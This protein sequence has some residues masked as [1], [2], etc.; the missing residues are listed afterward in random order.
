MNLMC[1]SQR[2]RKNRG[3]W[4]ICKWCSCEFEGDPVEGAFCSEDC[5]E[6]KHESDIEMEDLLSMEDY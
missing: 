4:K 5:F 1:E 3:Q 2:R 6:A